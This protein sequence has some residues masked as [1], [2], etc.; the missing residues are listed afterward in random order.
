MTTVRNHFGRRAVAA[1]Y[2]SKAPRTP[3]EAAEINDSRTELTEGVALTRRTHQLSGLN[4]RPP[5]EVVN[6]LSATPRVGRIRKMN[7]KAKNGHETEP[8]PAPAA[9]AAW[10]SG[11]PRRAWWSTR[12]RRLDDVGGSD[13][14]VLR[15]AAVPS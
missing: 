7:R 1:A 11:H 12:Q 14:R 13:Q 6:A 4:E 5:D 9:P 15:Q 3:P 8:G 2:A 10:P